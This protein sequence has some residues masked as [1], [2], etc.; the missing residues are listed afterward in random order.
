[1]TRPTNA[2]LEVQR[3]TLEALI[4][5]HPDGVKQ[6]QLAADW[7]TTTVPPI[8]RR[9]MLR[10][11]AEMITAGRIVPTGAARSRAY[12]LTAPAPAVA[13]AMIASTAPS[14]TV[15]SAPYP[16]LSPDG[17]E[18]RQLVQRDR[19][20]R[21]PCTYDG[22][23]LGAYN[24]GDTW[25]LPAALRAKLR[26]LGSDPVA[27]Q[28]IGTYARHILE[29]LLVDLSFESSRLE[30]NH[31]SLLDTE[32][33][34]LFG[35][36]AVGGTP[37]EKQMILNHKS[38]IQF[39]SDN[40]A[41][42]DVDKATMYAVHGCLAENLMDDPRREGA[43]RTHAVTIY[44]SVYVPSAIP[45]MIEQWFT[46]LVSKAGAIPD[47]FEQAFVLLI[48][49]PYLQPFGD[50]NKRTSRVIANLPLIK[51]EFC[52]LSFL[53]VSRAAYAEGLLGVYELRR[54]E[55]MR[56]VFEWAYE[57]SCEQYRVVVASV[58]QPDRIRQEYRTA[59]R[60]YVRDTVR[61]RAKPGAPD[62]E[63]WARGTARVPEDA[64]PLFR[65]IS[66]ELENLRPEL[67][68]RY[69]LRPP[70]VTSWLTATR[71]G[72]VHGSSGIP[73]P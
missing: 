60:T 21:T 72:E 6:T 46:E 47:P 45:Q 50:V 2:Q 31:Y 73:R 53:D 66:L 4:A 10:R 68:F 35:T 13:T 63:E 3:T 34:L 8:D 26:T 55:L 58:G 32:K 28:P 14:V 49:V 70:D 54:I 67:A 23:F 38:A 9:T 15:Q 61:G 27:N 30:G 57:R 52:P 41:S 17:T 44:N 36:E 20:L 22:D 29:R 16:T 69:D 48:H 65:A 56:D 24:P 43:L 18:V 40:A 5:K 62:M 42:L 7:A 33:L 25:Y 12:R 71:I 11:L 19:S 39:I 37:Q 64:G 51:A 59:L 1:M